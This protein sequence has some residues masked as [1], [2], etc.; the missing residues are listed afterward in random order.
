MAAKERENLCRDS[1]SKV[2]DNDKKD[3]G[4]LLP[5]C[6]WDILKMELWFS[7]YLETATIKSC[8][9]MQ[10]ATYTDHAEP[11]YD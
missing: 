5:N 9:K 6:K 7:L 1:H 4:D 10:R 11:T 3:I 2:Q 8:K